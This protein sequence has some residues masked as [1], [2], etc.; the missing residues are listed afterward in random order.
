MAS[1]IYILSQ[2]HSFVDYL[3]QPLKKDPNYCVYTHTRR[4]TLMATI[5]RFIRNI[6]PGKYPGLWSDA[7]FPPEYRN[8]LKGI[9]P[10]D[11]VIFWAVGN[12]KDIKI[13]TEDIK[14]S[15]VSSLLWDPLRQICH[16]S[17]REIRHYP[18]IMQHLNIKVCTFDKEDAR[19]YGFIYVGQ[20]YRY[21]DTS[22]QSA[23]ED[24]ANVLFIGV[25]K[26]RA[27]KLDLVASIFEK[28]QIPYDFRIL[29]DKHSVRGRYPQLDKCEMSESIPYSEVLQ[30][31]SCA[32]CLLDIL[33]PGQVGMTMRVLEALFLNKK[34]ITDNVSIKDEPF[35]RPNNIYI[36][37][38][39][40]Q[41]WKS[42]KE[43]L[44]S[45]YEE[46]SEAI[47]R[48]YDIKK[49]IKKVEK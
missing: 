11:K 20:V 41:P 5:K 46:V 3:L 28:E 33:Q 2:P 40:N 17:D 45:P 27:D 30:I 25:D 21:L 36:I 10:E 13:I 48:E 6:L 37:N 29:Y 19:K 39:F 24:S 47:V 44:D 38:D 31:S 42:V 34:L 32:G 4:R 16:F 22:I 43:F 14:N 8:L 12:K 7:I 1:K 49:W 18:S 26:R 23:S 35:Y 9:N 15:H